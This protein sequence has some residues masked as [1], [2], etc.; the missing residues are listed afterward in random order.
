[1]TETKTKKTKEPELEKSIRIFI[2]DVRTLTGKELVKKFRNEHVN[3]DDPN[4][5]LGYK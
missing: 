2:S 4:L 1:M 5:I 3:K